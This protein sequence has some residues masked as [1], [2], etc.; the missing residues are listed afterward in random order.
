MERHCLKSGHSDCA[1]A[2][3]PAVGP[4]RKVASGFTSVIVGHEGQPSYQEAEA[5]VQEAL[6]G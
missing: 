4:W 2:T 5:G 6:I 1:M 3:P